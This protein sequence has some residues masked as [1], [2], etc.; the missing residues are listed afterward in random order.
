MIH[1]RS[2]TM[3]ALLLLCA[4]PSTANAAGDGTI[5]LLGGSDAGLV[6][7]D[8]LI[9]GDKIAPASDFGFLQADGDGYAFAGVR[10]R[11]TDGLE[12]TDCSGGLAPTDTG[13]VFEG[14]YACDEEL[15]VKLAYQPETGKILPNFVDPHGVWEEEGFFVGSQ[16]SVKV[17]PASGVA[18]PPDALI[19]VTAKDAP[20]E[21][22]IGLIGRVS[23]EN[24]Q[25]SGVCG[26]GVAVFFPQLTLAGCAPSGLFTD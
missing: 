9:G 14:A 1:R 22:L 21:A 6:A 13:G 19:R 20:A 8:A 12:V 5:L 18:I 17:V 25:Q 15:P 4:P 26:D 23:P 11:V 2:A 24:I 3:A 16:L 10:V 7:Y